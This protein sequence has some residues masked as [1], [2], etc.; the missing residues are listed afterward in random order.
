MNRTIYCYALTA[1]ATASVVLS[2]C[3][4]HDNKGS[5]VE[6]NSDIASITEGPGI[7]KGEGVLDAADSGNRADTGDSRLEVGKIAECYQDICDEAARE[8]TLGSLEVTERIVRR[9]GDCGYTAVDSE[10]QIDMTGAERALQFC[11]AAKQME[12]AELT[13]VVVAANGGFT[14]YCLC[15][16]EGQISVVKEY[17]QYHNGCFENGIAVS[18]AVDSWELTEEGYFIFSGSSYSQQSYVLT[19]SDVPEITALRIEPLDARCRE[20]NRKY[21]LPVGYRRNNMFLCDWN[22]EDYGELDFYD[23]F[24]IFYPTIYGQPVPYIAEQDVRVRAVYS[25]PEEEF[26][27]VIMEYLP[28]KPEMLRSKTVYC[29]KDRA[30]EYSPRGFYE[31]EYPNI[32]YPEV[33]DYT[34]NNDGT[35]TLTVNGV[36]PEEGTSRAFTH[37][38]TV[39]RLEDGKFQYV[40]NKK[41]PSMDD[42]GTGWHTERLTAEEWEE[43]K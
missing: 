32:P 3:G 39:R 15:A 14:V 26:E 16:E 17:R 6:R 7:E 30:Y 43:I 21:I 41:I 11:Q 12:K 23:L 20:M 2:G 24:D 28:V 31:T 34:E 25:I 29:A 19:M 36:Y 18:Y 27:T 1:V 4:S 13:V 42:Y 8:G 5:N 38:V 9:L 22:K 40:S 33:T 37:E 10:N 35:V